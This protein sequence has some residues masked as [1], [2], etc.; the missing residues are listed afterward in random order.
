MAKRAGCKK[1][2]LTHIYPICVDYD[3]VKE[4]EETFDGEVVLAEDGM[5]FTLE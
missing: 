5:K 3:L 4:C 1:L 2:A